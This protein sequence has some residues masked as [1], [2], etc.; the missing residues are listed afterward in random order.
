MIPTK[1]L[2]RR[3]A[4][5][6]AAG[7]EP[8]RPRPKHAGWRYTHSAARLTCRSPSARLSPCARVA[9]PVSPCPRVAST[10]C[11][12][13][14]KSCQ[15]PAGFF[16]YTIH[17]GGPTDAFARTGAGLSALY[18]A[19]VYTGS[20]ID[21][22]LHLLLTCKP[23]GGAAIFRP[24]M[25]YFYGHYYAAQAMWTAGGRWSASWFPAIRDELLQ[26][27]NTDGSWDDQ[28]DPH[29]ASPSPASFSESPTT[30]CPI[31]QK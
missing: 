8:D 15:A 29:Y 5:Q 12:T 16:K 28:I 10:D 14:V 6:A 31:L 19:G 24:D 30:T 20:E 7:P 9:T 2:R 26:R 17:G 21:K 27:Q 25:Q 23:T 13:Y 4:Q 11:I 22:G 1:G 18:S 3:D